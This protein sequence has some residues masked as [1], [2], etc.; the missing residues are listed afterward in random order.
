ML[1]PFGSWNQGSLYSSTA[2]SCQASGTLQG[3]L[4]FALTQFTIES[5]PS[6]RKLLA[7]LH[8]RSRAHVL[9]LDATLLMGVK[10]I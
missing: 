1:D 4:S 6:H 7:F 9:L 3:Y 5:R 8:A 10:S 2:A